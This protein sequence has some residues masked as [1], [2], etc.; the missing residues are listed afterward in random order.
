MRKTTVAPQAEQYFMITQV[1]FSP[2][3]ALFRLRTGVG[4]LKNGVRTPL[5]MIGGCM[6][7][8]SNRQ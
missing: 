2:I 5:A 7:R 4:R 6:G 8:G 3:L 1:W